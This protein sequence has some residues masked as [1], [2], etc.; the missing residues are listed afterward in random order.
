MCEK[1]VLIW[2]GEFGPVHADKRIDPEA[3]KTN[4]ARFEMLKE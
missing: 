2:N 1:K 4:D 3:D